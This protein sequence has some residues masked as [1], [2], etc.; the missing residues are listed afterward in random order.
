AGTPATRAKIEMSLELAARHDASVSLLSVIDVER[1]AKVG[2]IP[3]G[4]GHS[5]RQMSEER[6][7]QSRRH[8][9]EAIDRFVA[10]AEQRGIGVRVL[11][12]E[13]DP[14]T[15]LA[16]AWRTHDLC[17]L[18]LRGWFDHAVVA[19]PEGALMRLITQ[20]VRPILALPETS[21]QISTVLIA[22][23]GSMESAKAMKRFCQMRLWPDARVEIAMAGGDGVDPLL[24]EAAEYVGDHGFEVGTAS[25]SGPP[26]RALLHH[27]AEIDADLVVLGS[28]F[29]S[30]LL[31]KVFGSTT[32]TMVKASERPLLLSH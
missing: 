25:L 28:G 27:A 4:G 22:Y 9:G 23:N 6:A 31:G 3:V 8:A 13:G 10:T 24:T 26:D 11:R 29:R 18:G 30:A 14:F 15:S 32:L 5:A 12:D 16:R 20:G 7:R 19:E 1:L 21:R 17:L 2:P